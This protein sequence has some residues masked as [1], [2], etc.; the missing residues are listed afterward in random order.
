MKLR[1]LIMKNFKTMIL[2]AIFALL[3]IMIFSDAK[4]L[5]PVL[6]GISMS[7]QKLMT[8]PVNG[9]AQTFVTIDNV[10]SDGNGWAVISLDRNE[11]PKTIL[12][13]AL[14]KDGSNRNVRVMI[15]LTKDL[16]GPIDLYVILHRD[17]GRRGVFEFPGPDAPYLLTGAGIFGAFLKPDI[18]ASFIL[19]PMRKVMDGPEALYE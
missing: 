14:V 19:S 12:G 3:S 18:E 11:S 5:F 7:D 8:T 4:G 2:T 15:N 9:R 16:S 17:A 10:T 6:P 1:R 13:F